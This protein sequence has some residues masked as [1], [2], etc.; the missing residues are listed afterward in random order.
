[1]N[2]NTAVILAGGKSRRFGKDK[3]LASFGEKSLIEHIYFLLEPLFDEVFI[4]SDNTE[5]YH[6]TG[7]R[8]LPDLHKESGPLGGLHA[9][10]SAAEEGYVFIT[11]CD[12]PFISKV[13]ITEMQK[14]IEKSHPE[15]V[16]TSHKGFIEPF[17]AFYST[18][19]IDK[20]EKRLKSS[21][22]GLLA[23]L[24]TISPAIIETKN[25]QAFVN[26]NTPEDLI[27]NEKLLSS[28]NKL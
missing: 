2:S 16:V 22:C 18:E 26:I 25:E 13:L 3:A 8:V 28:I 6:C 14:I 11:A 7:A 24:R 21:P 4:I 15:A 1:M 17:H 19:L 9:A 5:K 12:M 20:I 27:I 10:L 23:F